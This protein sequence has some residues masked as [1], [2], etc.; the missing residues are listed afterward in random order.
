[1]SRKNKIKIDIGAATELAATLETLENNDTQLSLVVHFDGRVSK[2]IDASVALPDKGSVDENFRKDRRLLLIRFCNYIRKDTANTS[3]RHNKLTRFL[4]LLK[5]LDNEGCYTNFQSQEA[6]VMALKKYRER[7]VARVKNPDIK[8]SKNSASDY[9]KTISVV[10]QDFLRLDAKDFNT[11]F[12]N[13]ST[14]TDRLNAAKIEDASKEGKTFTKNDEKLLFKI[15]LLAAQHYKGIHDN[16]LDALCLSDNRFRLAYRDKVYSP[17]H[18]IPSIK[19]P[20]YFCLNS[21]TLM[22]SLMFISVTGINKEGALT[23]K[24]KDIRI[25]STQQNRIFI[26]WTC[27]RK[28]K[29]FVDDLQMEKSKLRYFEEVMEHSKRID[30]SDDGLLFPWVNKD[31][32]STLYIEATFN[33]MLNV[34]FKGKE[35][36]V[37]GEYG[38][39][40]VPVPTKLRNTH[41]ENSSKKEGMKHFILRN[42]ESTTARHYSSTNASENNKILAQGMTEYTRVLLGKESIQSQKKILET[43]DITVVSESDKT[44]AKTADGGVC[45]NSLNSAEASKYKRKL[46]KRGI[47]LEGEKHCANILACFICSNHLFVDAIENIYVLLSFRKYLLDSR[48]THQSGGLFGDKPLINT[49][50]ERIEVLINTKFNKK[51]VDAATSKLVNKGLHPIWDM[52]DII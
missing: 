10:A 26:K 37:V 16:G 28:G 1:M 25:D 22:Y 43:I 8:L 17:R 9:R 4:K 2:K 39:L 42:K 19:N 15:F 30:S 18:H 12:P 34:F 41:A 23:A 35:V 11:A 44:L 14:R 50:L 31:G 5:L 24:R 38:E 29:L 33:S 45:L 36:S 40:L 20:K 32:T 6:I 7:M 48:Y 3:T 21:A 13:F 46:E 49:T 27:Y 51:N 52:G 47:D